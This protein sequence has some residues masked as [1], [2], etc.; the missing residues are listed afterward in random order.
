MLESTSAPNTT[1]SEAESPKVNV[2]PLNVL[3][4]VTVRLPPTLRSFVVV[5]LP[6]NVVVPVT[7]RVLDSVAA[8]VTPS[9][10]ATVAF[11][12]IS[13]VSI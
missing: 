8:P 1:L 9:V 6:V 11:S 13:S 10:P 3:V 4:P 12:S 2:P 5:T 7:A